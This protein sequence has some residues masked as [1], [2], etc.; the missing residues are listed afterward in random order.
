MLLVGTTSSA[1]SLVQEKRK[2]E[3]KKTNAIF[4]NLDDETVI[5]FTDNFSENEI[6]II[7]KY[8]LHNVESIIRNDNIDKNEKNRVV[9]CYKYVRERYKIFNIE[10][11]NGQ[12]YLT[13]DNILFIILINHKAGITFTKKLLGKKEDYQIISF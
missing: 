10:P 4:H 5:N 7:T 1:S 12:T 3:T 8:N 11:P 13:L 6:N 2:I 9:Q